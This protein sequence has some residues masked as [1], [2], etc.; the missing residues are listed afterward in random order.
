MIR[1]TEEVD[2]KTTPLGLKLEDVVILIEKSKSEKHHHKMRQ[3]QIEGD[4]TSALNFLTEAFHRQR[5]KRVFFSTCGAKE[6]SVRAIMHASKSLFYISGKTKKKGESR[7]VE[8]MAVFRKTWQKATC[9][10][11]TGSIIQ[12]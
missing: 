6:D 5:T 7:V 9:Q 8:M 2:D 12:N 3:E 10:Y 11:G 1:W 4:Q